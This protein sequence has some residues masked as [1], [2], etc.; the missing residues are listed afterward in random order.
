V[1]ELIEENAQLKSKKVELENEHEGLFERLFEQLT[2]RLDSTKKE[3][4][5]LE[6]SINIEEQELKEMQHQLE[7]LESS[8]EENTSPTPRP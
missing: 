7:L 4:E 3:N 1:H 6:A 2:Q 5:E 8:S